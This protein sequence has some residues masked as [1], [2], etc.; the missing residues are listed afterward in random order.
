[1][2]ESIAQ[3]PA[4]GMA[5]YTP[6]EYTAEAQ[7]FRDTDFESTYRAV[8]GSS[9]APVTLRYI[10]YYRFANRAECDMLVWVRRK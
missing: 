10:P 2:S 8:G 4:M 1:M 9:P 6:G 3:L 7:G 5:A